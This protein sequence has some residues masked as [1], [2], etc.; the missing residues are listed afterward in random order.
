MTHV[1]ICKFR[2]YCDITGDVVYQSGNNW[3]QIKGNQEQVLS[4]LML[5]QVEHYLCGLPWHSLPMSHFS[6]QSRSPLV[7][8]FI[9]GNFGKHDYNISQLYSNGLWVNRMKISNNKNHVLSYFAY[10]V[11]MLL[12]RTLSAQLAMKS[13]PFSERQCPTYHLHRQKPVHSRRRPENHFWGCGDFHTLCICTT[14]VGKIKT[15]NLLSR[16]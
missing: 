8:V 3:T 12:F 7:K 2:W 10:I 11:K 16:V 5:T 14:L 1:Y 15:N 9:H 6:L 4:S 13:V